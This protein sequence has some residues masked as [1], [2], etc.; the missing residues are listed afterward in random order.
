MRN[1]TNLEQ[2]RK[3]HELGIA[4]WLKKRG[5]EWPSLV[6]G[7]EKNYPAFPDP[8]E[9]H[10]VFAQRNPHLAFS[11]YYYA[12]DM[13]TAFE[14][15]E[16]RYGLRW[17]RGDSSYYFWPGRGE[18]TALPRISAFTASEL[19]EKRLSALILAAVPEVPQ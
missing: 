18:L 8:T 12:V 6:W 19:L 11:R 3:L 5:Q 4:D 1:I 9:Y 7:L 16:E 10:L 17:Y 15:L 14:F 2:S 13:L